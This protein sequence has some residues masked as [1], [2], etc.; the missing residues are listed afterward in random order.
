MSAAIRKFRSPLAML[1]L[2]ATGYALSFFQRVNPSVLAPD[3]MESFSLDAASFSLI[4]SATMLGYAITQ[5]PSGLLA[6]LIGGRRTL[7]AYQMLAGM[8]CILFTFCGS[9]APAVAC[10]FL[11]GLTLASNIPSYKLIASAVPANKYALYCS[12]L[13]G[14]GIIGT[15]MAASP[16]VAA[17]HLVGWRAALFAVGVFTVFLGGAIY[18]L[19]PDYD[20]GPANCG[21]SF[22]DNL[23]GLKQGMAQVIRMRNFW[24]IFVWFMF[25]IGNLFVLLTTWWGSYLMQA[26]GLSKDA[27]GL[28]ISIMSLVPLPFMLLFPWLSDNVVRSRKLFLVVAAAAQCL[29][30]L[31]ICLHRSSPLS[32]WTL[33][34]LGTLFT[35]F[36]NC[37]GPIS[38]TMV[39]ECVPS[40]AL[41]SASGFINSSAP[42]LAAA[43]QWLFGLAVTVMVAGGH[44]PLEGFASAF[45]LL[46]AGSCI[47]LV[48]SLFMQDTLGRRE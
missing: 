17:T 26:N 35:I 29:I 13:T 24:L 1:A 47:A 28:S 43:V 8:F 40:S 34:I 27:A 2:L 36:T 7:A 11:L 14:C 6:D 46:L 32:F 38:F 16:L 5:I 12:A 9:F 37:M 10:R 42:V 23:E 4:S 22:R 45:F 25:M 33:T 39:K 15:L 48:C 3:L 21:S 30:L 19:I 18:L 20:C 31:F 44:T 41:A